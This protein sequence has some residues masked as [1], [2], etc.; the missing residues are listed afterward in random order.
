MGRGSG[1]LVRGGTLSIVLLSLQSPAAC[2]G[3]EGPTLRIER[4]DA[5][6]GASAPGVAHIEAH[7]AV[8]PE[9][10]RHLVAGS[11][12]VAPDRS[13]WDC[14]AFVSRDG[15]RTWNRHQFGI[16]RCIDPWVHVLPGGTVLFAAIRIS[17]RGAGDARLELLLHRS[18]D[19]GE[20]WSDEPLRLG[21][22][23]EHPMMTASARAP[24][25]VYLVARRTLEAADGTGRHAAWIA[26]STDG[27]AS[28]MVAQEI[29]PFDLSH[30]PNGAAVLSDGRV[31]VTTADYDR[32]VGGD[33]PEDAV[34]RPRAWSLIP[35]EEPRFV[36]DGCGHGTVE[37]GFAGYPF[38]AAD[39]TTGTFRDRL[40]F[41]CVRPGF[42][43]VALTWADGP[44]PWVE[45]RRVDRTSGEPDGRDHVRTP[46]VA[47][48]P[49]G[50]LAV[51]WYDR[52][53]DPEDACQDVYFTASIDGGE[54]FADPLRLSEETSCPDASG[55]G[56]LAES[57]PALG[58]Y[59]ALVPLPGRQFLVIW[60]DSRSG[61]SRLRSA[62]VRV[63]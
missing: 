4:A 62:V 25:D 29:V 6:L 41:A 3:Q 34:R 57:W 12:V 20:T 56:S 52:R 2:A 18:V 48:G 5:P 16:H 43:G 35:G 10:P 9:N 42:D 53:H 8:H 22:G 23:F 24:G 60:P 21:P 33:G 63:E 28:F 7:G 45:P 39:T 14:A 1:M 30:T 40:Y 46:V 59:G 15:G 54:T 11:I 58:D 19:G 47:V 44:G 26:R 49:E 61:M 27:G 55:N 36:T 31:V 13:A 50:T 38:L 32:F 37:G 51:T 17:D